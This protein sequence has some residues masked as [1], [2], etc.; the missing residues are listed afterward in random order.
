MAGDHQIS[1]G[2]VATIHEG[3]G[4]V[5]LL[6]VDK[7]RA[8]TIQ[9]NI[10]DRPL[11]EVLNEI[12]TKITPQDLGPGV[13]YRFTGQ[14]TSMNDSF[15]DMLQALA[16]SLVLVYML[17]AILYESL[18]TPFIR[19]FSLPLGLIGSLLFLVMTHNTINLYSLIG[20][21]VMDG[22]VAKNGTLLL[23]YTLTLMDQGDRCF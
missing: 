1:L 3:T 21:L 7:Q 4:P 12:K 22:L 20:I 6:R 15:S 19:M 14:A 18:L 8:I 17:L 2:D 9:A 23:D 5:M 11:Q 10:T 13:T 16:L